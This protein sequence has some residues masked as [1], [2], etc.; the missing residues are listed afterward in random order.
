MYLEH[1]V[2]DKLPADAIDLKPI[3]EAIG[4]FCKGTD[5]ERLIWARIAFLQTYCEG[6]F[7]L[8]HV[9]SYVDARLAPLSLDPWHWAQGMS[10][11]AKLITTIQESTSIGSRAY[12]RQ[13]LL[14]L[15]NGIWQLLPTRIPQRETGVKLV[16]LLTLARHNDELK[17]WSTARI[18]KISRH[19]MI[20][21]LFHLISTSWKPRF[22]HKIP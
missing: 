6:C 22:C 4:W 17:C 3:W 18:R 2:G 12:I 13:E 15:D 7:R 16:N 11:L 10:I 1:E 21:S 14:I 19:H 5:E 20:S 8:S 9:E